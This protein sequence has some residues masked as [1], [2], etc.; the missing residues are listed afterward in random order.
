MTVFALALSSATSPVY[1][2]I[3]G[4]FKAYQKGSLKT[5]DHHIWDKLLK[6]YVHE[7][8]GG[9]NRVDYRRFKKTGHWALKNYLRMLQDTNVK[10]LDRNEQF[11]FW[12]NL[13]NAKTLDVVLDRYPVSSIKIIK[14]GL[15]SPGPWKLINMKV[16]GQALTL[17][18]VEHQILRGL[19]RD[20]RIHY[21]VNCASV[22]CPNLAKE[23][24]TGNNM[25]KLLDAG[26]RAYINS[27]RGVNIKSGRMT[28]S[29]IYKWFKEDF[30]GNERG[31]LRHLG[32]YATPQLA[33]RLKK[34]GSISSYEYD[35]SL[36]DR[37]R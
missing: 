21:A 33:A 16:N 19:W 24:Y 26:A 25:Q 4:I 29:K 1:A 2:D 15:F 11:A 34:I 12:V 7:Y 6:S 9:L 20:P 3:A 30:G 31:I 28:V 8:A 35:W 5:V 27:R 17:D 32:F 14:S 22:G 13:Y 10:A 36:N 23:A 18:N 37:Q